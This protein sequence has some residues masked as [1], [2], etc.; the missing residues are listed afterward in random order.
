M[1]HKQ[2]RILKY[3]AD[4]FKCH[5]RMVI[6]QRRDVIVTNGEFCLCI[7]LVTIENKKYNLQLGYDLNY[8]IIEIESK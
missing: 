2:T 8:H 6:F 3:L 7:D 4:Y 5:S 1:A